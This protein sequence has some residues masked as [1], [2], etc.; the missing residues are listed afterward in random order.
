M[1]S[2]F[3]LSLLESFMSPFLD[4]SSYL[5]N[6]YT[7]AH[8]HKPA[9]GQT[10]TQFRNTSLFLK[11]NKNGMQCFDL[12][13]A[14]HLIFLVSNHIYDQICF[15]L[16][17]NEFVAFFIG[18][19]IIWVYF[20]HHYLHWLLCPLVFWFKEQHCHFWSPLQGCPSFILVPR[21]SEIARNW[22][23]TP[24]CKY[25]TDGRASRNNNMHL[26]VW[27]FGKLTLTLICVKLVHAHYCIDKPACL[28][29]HVP[30]CTFISDSW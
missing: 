13:D 26:F 25:A 23:T 10:A 7:L 4:F 1:C 12:W 29:S 19:Q 14:G 20:Y 30:H 21:S 2:S 5:Q 27:M 17:V 8:N 28:L 24:K 11:G 15:P 3:T 22:R 6:N 9:Y 16:T 18:P